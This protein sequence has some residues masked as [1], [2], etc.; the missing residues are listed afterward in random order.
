MQFEKKLILCSIFAVAIG[1]ATVTPLA[2]LMT[3]ATAQST[4]DQPRL[5]FNMAYAYVRNVWDNT[6]LTNETYGWAFSFVFETAP[7]FGL[8]DDSVAYYETFRAELSSD[9][10]SIGNISLSAMATTGINGPPANLTFFLD[11]WY[12]YTAFETEKGPVGR[13]GPYNGTAQNF[14]NGYDYNWNLTTGQP[15]SLVMK[16]Y[17][18]NSIIRTLNST[19]I[20]SDENSEPIMQLKLIPYRDG[21]LYNTGIPMQELDL[22]NPL[23][24]MEKMKN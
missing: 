8:T 24:P 20:Y 14:K 18:E 13:A 22:I 23:F 3:P 1:I 4:D 6:T 15:Q 5:S 9:D 21:Y 17:R 16:I 7:I 12:N 11:N 10:V 19:Q 2:F